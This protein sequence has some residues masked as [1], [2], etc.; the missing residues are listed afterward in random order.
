[1]AIEAVATV[2]A[3]EVVAKTA[4]KEVTKQLAEKIA[5]Q[6]I[7]HRSLEQMQNLDQLNRMESFRLGEGVASDEKLKLRE[8]NAE[9]ELRSKIN[10]DEE[11]NATRGISEDSPT[12]TEVKE[13]STR[14]DE[15][16]KEDIQTLKEEY[17]DDITKNSEVPET[18][19]REKILSSEFEK[20][21]VEETA[22]NRDEFNKIKDDL[23]KQWEEQNGKEW[24]TYKEDVYSSNEHLIRRAGDKYDAHHIQP[25]SQGGKNEVSNITPLHAE[26]HYD[27]QGIHSPNSPYAKIEQKL[28]A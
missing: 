27:R 1:M 23:I 6:S 12:S 21:S 17:V 22:Q 16:G 15:T 10:D 9:N 18:I 14:L 19:D 28:G 20:S 2:A 3:K 26:N 11:W 25:L 7:E 8:E 13:L 5:T 4:A 24:P